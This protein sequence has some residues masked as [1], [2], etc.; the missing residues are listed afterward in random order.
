MLEVQVDRWLTRRIPPASQVRLNQR[1]I[2]ILPSR[3]GVAFG[4]AL[5]PML[6]VAINYQ[7]SLAY[8]LTFLLLSVF[9][10]AILHTWRNLS[11]LNLKAAG[12]A[13]VFLGEQAHFRVTLES[14]GRE[15]QAVALGW[16]P[17]PLH[18]QDVPAAGACDVELHQ[19][20]ASRGWLRPRRLRVESRYPLG[21]LVAW[22][23]VDLDQA[24]LVYPRPLEGDLPLMPGHGEDDGDDGQHVLGAGADDYQG[25]RAYQPGDSRR[26]LHWKAY[27]RGQGLFVKDFAALAGRDLWLD[28]EPLEGNLEQRLGL[29]CHWVLQFSSRGQPFGLRLGGQELAPN[30]GDAH[31]EACLRA[32]ALFEGGR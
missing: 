29:L 28:L 32:L 9:L 2:F 23:W 31:R 24:L 25:L 12:G 4:L 27:S 6:L 11:G 14:G 30:T 17:L 3:A 7:N 13:P 5:V 16:P 8:G 22:S 1:R 19:P 21:L 18:V 20:T 26:R 10:V 15:H